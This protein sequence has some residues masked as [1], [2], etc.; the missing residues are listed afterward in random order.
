ERERRQAEA[1]YSAVFENSPDPI[2]I[3]RLSDGQLLAVNDAW[4][5]EAGYSRDQALGRSAVALGIADAS[6]A[7]E[8]YAS[9][10]GEGRTVTPLVTFARP[11]GSL[12]E[13]MTSGA[14]IMI[15]EQEC[16]VWQSRDMTEVERER[17]RN[18]ALLMNVARGVSAE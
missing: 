14:R 10:R 17:R 1:R 8:L 7:A 11:D 3:T 16:A 15:G 12:R 9:L 5:R 2:A 6:L 4:V 18:E 13:V